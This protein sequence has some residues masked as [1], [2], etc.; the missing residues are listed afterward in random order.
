MFD[1]VAAARHAQ[2]VLPGNLPENYRKSDIGPRA[3]HSSAE[4]QV[5]SSMP[6]RWFRICGLQEIV[7]LGGERWDNYSRACGGIFDANLLVEILDGPIALF[8]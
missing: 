6:L 8:C 5:R 1:S 3:G 4:R 7:R 2:S